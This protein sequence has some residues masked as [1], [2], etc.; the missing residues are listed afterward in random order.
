MSFSLSSLSL[1][2]KGWGG[3]EKREESRKYQF[4]RLH[5]CTWR[6]GGM[7]KGFR[8]LFVP[9]IAESNK[10]WRWG[11]W[12]SEV[13]SGSLC[14]VLKER[15]QRTRLLTDDRGRAGRTTPTMA[16]TGELPSISKSVTPCLPCLSLYPDL[17]KKTNLQ[18][19]N[20][21]ISCCPTGS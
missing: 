11:S 5:L 2:K 21:Y 1:K 6:W 20:W 14:H 4:Q 17:Q 7:G 3:R 16:V 18:L 12:S 15:S 13:R 10:T 9:V 8:S 19:I